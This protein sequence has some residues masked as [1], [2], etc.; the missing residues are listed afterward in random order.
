MCLVVIDYLQLIESVSKSNRE[1]EV[2]YISR[3]I[4][5]TAKNLNIPFIQLS[6]LNRDLRK[7]PNKRPVRSDIRESASI[8]HDSDIILFLYRDEFYDEE[9]T[10]K[11]IAEIDI[12]KHRNGDTGTVF[13][14]FKGEYNRF[15]N[16]SNQ[17]YN[18]Y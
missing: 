17:T 9:T 15:E 10:D 4:K 7:R 14:R 12:N 13:L 8:E 18:K 11:G 6:Q 2:A 3:T 16:S 5:R 1:Q